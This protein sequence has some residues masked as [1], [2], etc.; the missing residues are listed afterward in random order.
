M[1]LT[2]EAGNG[3]GMKEPWT[4]LGGLST[5][6]EEMSLQ[7]IFLLSGNAVTNPTIVLIFFLRF[8]L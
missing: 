4:Y 8:I 1:V 2:N 3:W 7:H 5:R 6:F